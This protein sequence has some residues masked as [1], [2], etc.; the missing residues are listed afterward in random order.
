M[1]RREVL[2]SGTHRR[3]LVMNNLMNVRRV[4]GIVVCGVV[5]GLVGIRGVEAHDPK[6]DFCHFKNNDWT[7]VSLSESAIEGHLEIG[8]DDGFPGGETSQSGTR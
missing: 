1:F 5:F 6:K 7:L 8:H 4:W 2:D 3:R